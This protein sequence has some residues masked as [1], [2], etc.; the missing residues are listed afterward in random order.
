MEDFIT[1]A[2]FT[3]PLDPSPKGELRAELKN[4]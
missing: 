1:I 2:I 4:L 3:Y